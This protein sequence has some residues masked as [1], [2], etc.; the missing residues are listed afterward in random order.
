[1]GASPWHAALIVL[2]VPVLTGACTAQRHRVHD[3]GTPAKDGATDAALLDAGTL[4]GGPTDSAPVQSLAAIRF[5]PLP[6][7][8]MK[9]PAVSLRSAERELKLYYTLDGSLPSDT[10][11]PYID[12]IALDDTTLVRVAGY[13]DGRG[14]YHASASYVELAEDV[15]DFTSNLPLIVVHMLDGPAPDSEM[16]VHVPAVVQLHVPDASG[17]ARLSS[18]PAE[19]GRVGIKVHGR[20]TRTQEKKSY[21][22]EFRTDRDDDDDEHARMLDLPPQSDWVLYAPYTLDRAIIRNSL[23]YHF[24]NSVGR[25]APRTRFVEMFLA[26]AGQ[27]VDASKYIGVYVAIESLKR[28][29]QRVAIE[30]LDI[31]DTQLPSISGGYLMRADEPDLGEKTYSIVN[32]PRAM[33]LRYPKPDKLNHEQEQYIVDYLDACGR[34]AGAPDRID[35]ITGSSLGDLIDTE[36]F[37]DTHLLNLFAKNADAWRLSSY[38]HKPRA[39]KLR[40]GPVWDCDRCMGSYDHRTSDP[41]GWLASGSTVDYFSWGW[42]GGIFSDPAFEERYWARLED[43]LSG[44]LDT[45]AVDAAIDAMADQLDE[46]AARNAARYPMAAPI[47]GSFRNEIENIRSWLHARIRWSKDNLRKR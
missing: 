47:D 46:A 42:W 12:P 22:L 14:S 30:R 20:R 36:S 6:G 13:R 17:R 45:P 44:P 39:G 38:F 26:D 33:V 28:D 19:L 1:M 40:A 41:A 29:P 10:S 8:F 24:S 27:R 34:A 15:A 4:E 43:W 32:M 23:F 11:T 16:D 18:E 5:E 9:M 3:A 25:Y 21:N 35:P 37:I 7:A 31:D 2:S